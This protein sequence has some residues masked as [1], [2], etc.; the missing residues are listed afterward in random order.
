MCFNLEDKI[1]NTGNLTP[2]A[3]GTNQNVSY[4]NKALTDTD[5]KKEIGE[6]GT[7][8]QR[9]Y[10]KSKSSEANIS[11]HS[12]YAKDLIFRI[13][14]A[15]DAKSPA[16]IFDAKTTKA[17]E[18]LFLLKSAIEDAQIKC[19]TTNLIDEALG[20]IAQQNNNSYFN[21]TEE[22][23]KTIIKQ[24]RNN[25]ISTP[26]AP[27]LYT[28]IMKLPLTNTTIAYEIVQNTSAKRSGE[29]ELEFPKAFGR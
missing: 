19:T 4:H 5:I 14:N 8:L 1:M 26:K 22:K 20:T 28:D 21:N 12:Q 29:N 13:R 25:N 9:N 3:S 16:S 7:T 10:S 17:E 2:Q 18:N 11:E 15:A 23:E 6:F 24:A 27:E